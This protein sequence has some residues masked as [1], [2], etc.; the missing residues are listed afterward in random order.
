MTDAAAGTLVH[1]AVGAR[2]GFPDEAPDSTP[3]F[4]IVIMEKRMT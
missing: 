2:A 3:T 4:F 1:P